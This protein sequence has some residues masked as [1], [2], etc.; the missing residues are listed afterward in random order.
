MM[1][2]RGRRGGGEVDEGYRERKA[3]QHLRAPGC[4]RV[5][6]NEKAFEADLRRRLVRGGGAGTSDSER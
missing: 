5:N 3:K 6:G 4:E 2:A 1:L